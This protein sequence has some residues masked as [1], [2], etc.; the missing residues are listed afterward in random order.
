MSPRHRRRRW[1]RSTPPAAAPG[2]PR[3]TPRRCSACSTQVDDE[4]W[5]GPTATDLL[6]Y[7]RENVARPLTVNAGLRGAAASQAE[8]SAWAAVWEQLALRGVR[9]AAEPW[10]VIWRTAQHAVANEVIAA[11]YGKSPR[12]AWDVANGVGV[13]P[14]EQLVG[15]H[16]LDWHPAGAVPDTL[17]ASLDVKTSFATAVTALQEVGWPST[18]AARIVATVSGLPYPGEEH[19]EAMSSRG[20]RTMATELDLPPWQARR[21]CVALLGTV[22]WPGLLARMVH[23]GPGARHSPAMQAALRCTRHRRLRSPVLTAIRADD[24]YAPG[25]PQLKAG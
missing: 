10:G 11:R 6:T 17:A 2:A 21:L 24:E 12:R 16:V 20:W 4:G 18:D 7:I 23:D 5:D 15:L 14:A 1:P 22:T 13:R 19:D 8:A 9:G 3:A 25:Y